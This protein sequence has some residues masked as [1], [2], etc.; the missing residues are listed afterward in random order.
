MSSD[1]K[2]KDVGHYPLPDT[3]RGSIARLTDLD[4]I[5]T[6][7][8]HQKGA[9]LLPSRALCD[10][11]VESFFAWA[12]PIVPVV[13]RSQ[14]MRR[15]RD[16]ENPPSLL[17]LQA[18]LLGGSKVCKNPQLMDANGSTTSA[19]RKFYKRAKALYEV[20]YEDDRVTIVQALVLMGWGWENPEGKLGTV[21]PRQ[22]LLL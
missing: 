22:I 5:D 15:Y 10:E 9:F 14:F 20:G 6:D 11:L 19:T 7:I 4:N 21:Q 8:L 3:V 1:G 2:R 13:N 16:D 12:F 18:I 17:L